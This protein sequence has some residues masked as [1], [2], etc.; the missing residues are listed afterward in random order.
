[1]LSPIRCPG[2]PSA[3]F[4]FSPFKPQSFFSFQKSSSLEIPVSIKQHR[5]LCMC[6]SAR[7]EYGPQR[8]SIQVLSRLNFLGVF[9]PC[10][11]KC[12]SLDYVEDSDLQVLTELWIV[13]FFILNCVIYRDSILDSEFPS[14]ISL[15]GGEA[16]FR[17]VLE[18]MESV[19]LSRN[20]TAKAI[21]D[22]VESADKSQICYDHLAF[23]TFGVILLP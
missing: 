19:Y 17:S 10:K 15:Q 9:F 1:M 8:S 13:I 18:G 7:S 22:L 2:K 4:S 5:Y 21:L 6:S 16:F 3:F 14:M 23:R 20:P 11:T 12:F